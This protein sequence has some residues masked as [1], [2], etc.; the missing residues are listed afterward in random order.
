MPAPSLR[1][2]A[3]SVRTSCQRGG[4]GWTVPAAPPPRAGRSPLLPHVAARAVA[5]VPGTGARERFLATSRERKMSVTTRKTLAAAVVVGAACFLAACG[6][7]G[8]A[9][10]PGPI[11]SPVPTDPVDPPVTPPS[12]YRSTALPGIANIPRSLLK[13]TKKDMQGKVVI[14]DNLV[15]HGEL[16]REVACTAYTEG[17]LGSSFLSENSVQYRR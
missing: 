14:Y 4:T 2:A 16:V 17:C 11:D 12:G 15:D 10:Q 8:P 5:A 3:P 9:T 1:P 13:A 7:G 6:G